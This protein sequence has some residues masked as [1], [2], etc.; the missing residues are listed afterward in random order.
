MELFMRNT[1][2]VVNIANIGTP[3]SVAV[4]LP[5]WHSLP[6]LE[7]CAAQQSAHVCKR[8]RIIRLHVA[9]YQKLPFAGSNLGGLDKFLSFPTSCEMA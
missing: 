1:P 8:Q 5:C 4:F 6:A 9:A 7:T 3:C 2:C